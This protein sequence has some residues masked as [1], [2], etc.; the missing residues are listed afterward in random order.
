[1]QEVKLQRSAS[2]SLPHAQPNIIDECSFFLN[3]NYAIWWL[4]LKPKPQIIPLKA[5]R[6]STFAH[7]ASREARLADFN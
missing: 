3:I 2:E 6:R 4:A 1:M 7:P 5:L